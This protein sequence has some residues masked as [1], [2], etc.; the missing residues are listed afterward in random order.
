M[1]HSLRSSLFY[2]QTHLVTLLKNDV[3]ERGAVQE[4]T[5]KA[6][7]NIRFADMGP[8]QFTFS[9]YMCELLGIKVIIVKGLTENDI[10]RNTDGVCFYSIPTGC[11][12]CFIYFLKNF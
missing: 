3:I 2:F 6:G 8:F 10:N 9:D 7:I 4:K 12:I 5:S 1:A 11:T